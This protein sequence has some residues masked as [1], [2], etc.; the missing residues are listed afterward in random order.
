MAAAAWST[1]TVERQHS[2]DRLR[3]V[4]L[5]ACGAYLLFGYA[6]GPWVGLPLLSAPRWL[7]WAFVALMP[8]GFAYA[9][10]ARLHIGRLWSGRVTIKQGHMIVRTGPYAL[11]RHPIYTGLLVAVA[12]TAVLVGQLQSFIG[13]VLILNGFIVK[14]RQEEQLLIGHFGDAYVQYRAE[15]PAL[16]PRVMRLR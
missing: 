16:I 10:W 1:R 9:W 13:F 4:V 11:T 15:V 8:F 2:S 3:H 7:Q 14:Y 5:V 12:S 6:R